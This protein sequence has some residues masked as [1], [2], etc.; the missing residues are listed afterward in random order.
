MIRIIA[1][2]GV[3]GRNRRVLLRVVLLH[4]TCKEQRPQPPLPHLDFDP[5]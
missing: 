5:I 4:P 1:R 2:K 3:S